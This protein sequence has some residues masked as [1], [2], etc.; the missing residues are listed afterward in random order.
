MFVFHVKLYPVALLVAGY[1]FNGMFI[2]KC[3]LMDLFFEIL[4]TF[5]FI[6]WLCGVLISIQAVRDSIFG[7]DF[8]FRFK[9]KTPLIRKHY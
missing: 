1:F 2:S 4:G 5:L 6:S 3:N 8:K 9:R 7:D